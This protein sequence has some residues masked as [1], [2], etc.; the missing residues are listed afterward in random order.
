MA[1][2]FPGP[3]EVEIHYTSNTNAHVQRLNCGL[4]TTPAPGDPASG[5]DL[6]LRGG[7]SLQ[8]DTAV[9]AW[10]NLLGAL[11]PTET[12]FD[13]FTLWKYDVGT[14][15][16]TFI[17]TEALAIDAT[18]GGTNTPDHQLALTFRT[19]EGG[20]MR[21]VLLES[22]ST[23][24]D[25]IPYA[26]AGQLIQDIMDFVVGTSNWILARDTS[27][28]IAFL[29]AVGGQNEALFKKAHR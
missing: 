14:F 28:P 12:T 22:Q 3:Y 16:K 6:S 7:G 5:I 2:N 9:I 29:N 1:Q 25:R 19:I 10:C 11:Y 8:L 15:D 17:T 20:T 18:G 24:Q 26:A 23:Q 27:F 13:N 4:T 21:V